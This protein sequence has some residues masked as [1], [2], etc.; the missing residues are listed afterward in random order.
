MT[1]WNEC[2]DWWCGCARVC[3]R[4]WWE[5]NGQSVKK[6]T[7]WAQK[8]GRGKSESGKQQMQSSVIIILW[9]K[10][11]IRL[12]VVPLT[13]ILLI[14]LSIFPSPAIS[15]AT[16]ADLIF[17]I[18]PKTILTITKRRL[19]N[20][21]LQLEISHS[22]AVECIREFWAISMVNMVPN[23]CWKFKN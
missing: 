13:T 16:M 10:S 21:I 12:S 20:A 4:A 14:H 5:K 23:Y 9:L 8:Y 18:S 2:W 22:T 17:K 19:D 11:T 6:I 3:V 1:L 7:P 15:S